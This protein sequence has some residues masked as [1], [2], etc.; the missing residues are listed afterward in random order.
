MEPHISKLLTDNENLYKQVAKLKILETLV[1]ELVKELNRLN[2][3]NLESLNKIE[4]W[5]K[6]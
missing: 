6:K 5:L 1:K 2:M 3:K 4:Q